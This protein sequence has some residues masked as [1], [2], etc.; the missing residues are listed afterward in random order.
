[1]GRWFIWDRCR[2]RDCEQFVYAIHDAVEPIDVGRGIAGVFDKYSETGGWEGY[3][4]R[5]IRV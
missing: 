2:I 4:L 3:V 1:M 5:R